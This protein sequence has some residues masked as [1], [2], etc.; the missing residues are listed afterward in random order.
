MPCR[1]RPLTTEDPTATSHRRSRVAAPVHPP[2]EQIITAE[3]PTYRPSTLLGAVQGR[4][5]AA[6]PEP[7]VVAGRVVDVRGQRGWVT[8][9]IGD[10]EPTGTP[11]PRL[12]VS[13]APAVVRRT[14]P[15]ALAL[16]TLVQVEGTVELW[17]AAARVQVTAREVVRIGHSQTQATYDAARAAITAER[18]GQQVPA[19]PLFLRRVL[20]LAPDGTTLGDLTRDLGG[21]QPPRIVH[22]PIP[23]DSPD[24]HRLVAAAVRANRDVDVVVLARGGTIEAISGWDDVELLRLLDRIQRA[25]IPVLLA[26]GH[27]QHTPLSYRVCGYTVRHTAEAGR[28][29]AEHNRTTALRIAHAA[30]ELPAALGRLLDRTDERI[31]QAA[32]R[33]Q[34]GL[35]GHLA[36]RERALDGCGTALAAAFRTRQRQ[37]EQRQAT[38]TAALTT[39]MHRCL[40]DAE[41]RVDLAAAT[42]GGFRSGI[43]L[44]ADVDGGVARFEVGARLRIEVA[45]ATAVATIDEVVHHDRSPGAGG[46]SR[47]ADGPSPAQGGTSRPPA[48][49]P[50][51]PVP[52]PA[53]PVGRGTQLRLDEES[54]G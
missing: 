15:E 4:L 28:W 22:R 3:R 19:L 47:V 38:V 33:A 31:G 49:P 1:R 53:P 20:L 35:A 2:C 18:L 39:T 21:W 54:E 30:T 52:P 10:A 9:T 11:P 40:T 36:A 41:R 5:R 44:V 27:A 12:E 50:A 43:A 37:A 29:L 24:L 45:D 16:Q 25:G 23:G 26:V 46:P 13:L 42:L 32:E 51:P 8:L 34:T 48:A 6:F 7:V 14:V 17:A